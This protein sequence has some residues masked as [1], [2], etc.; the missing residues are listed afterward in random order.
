MVAREAPVPSV[1][2]SELSPARTPA[3]SVGKPHVYIMNLGTDAPPTRARRER[4]RLDGAHRASVVGA[5]AS[6]PMLLPRLLLIGAA[7]AL[8][9]HFAPPRRPS[10]LLYDGR[11]TSGCS[12]VALSQPEGIDLGRRVREWWT[13]VGEFATAFIPPKIEEDDIPEAVALVQKIESS[14]KNPDPSDWG[15]LANLTTTYYKASFERV[16]AR[17]AIKNR[18]PDVFVALNG[19]LVLLVLRLLLPRLLA[20]QSM[21]DVFEFAP[22]LGLPS[23]EELLSYAEYASQMDY[24]TKFLLFLVVIIFEKVRRADARAPVRSRIG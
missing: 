23:R 22:E 3:G 5:A 7:C 15:I 19:A 1:L 8:Q 13:G 16:L 17:P 14:K 21:Q 24:A 2:N 9:P 20:I 6:L 11:R 10:V 18:L 12:P 4:E